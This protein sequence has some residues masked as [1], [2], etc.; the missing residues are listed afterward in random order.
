[1]DDA[2]DLAG[3]VL[4]ELQ[5]E[6]GLPAHAVTPPRPICIVEHPGS[7]VSDLGMAMTTTMDADAVRAAHQGHGNAEYD[8]LLVVPDAELAGFVAQAGEDLV[9]PAREFLFRL[10]LLPYGLSPPTGP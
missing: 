5:E 3:Q 10:G 8:P 6:L 7:G 1:P 2:L 4:T 9:P